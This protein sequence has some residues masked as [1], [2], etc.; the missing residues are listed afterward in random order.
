MRFQ[1]RTDP[2]WRPFVLIGGATRDNSYVEVT[3]E[4]ITLCFGLLFKRT[5]PR[6]DVKDVFVRSWPLWYGIGWRSNLRGVIGLVG[7]YTGVVEIRLNK[8]SR[9]WGVFPC[10]R[11]C[12]SLEHPDAFIAAVKGKPEE[13]ATKKKAAAKRKRKTRPRRAKQS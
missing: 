8:R 7:S 3:D 1:I 4:G 9:A 2:F 6:G 13:P 12:V 5:I 11:I 10:D